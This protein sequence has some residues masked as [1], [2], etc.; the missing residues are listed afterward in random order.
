[1]IAQIPSEVPADASPAVLIQAQERLR[2][3]VWQHARISAET[4]AAMRELLV[5]CQG[6]FD[7]EENSDWYEGMAS[8]A[9]W[10][11]KRTNELSQ[12]HINLRRSLQRLCLDAAQHLPLP[13]AWR[14][15]PAEFANF[16]LELAAHEELE[17]DL[18]YEAYL[19]DVGTKD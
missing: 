9:P 2:S 19:H 13:D 18:C 16:Q 10:L 7:S 4:A 12:Q 6:R 15:F 17:R 1:M 5:L 8:N 11:A 3:L 14:S